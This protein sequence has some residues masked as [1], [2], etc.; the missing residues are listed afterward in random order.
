MV[1]AIGSLITRSEKDAYPVGIVIAY[2]FGFIFTFLYW[3]VVQISPATTPS[4]VIL[5]CVVAG[6]FHGLLVSLLYTMVVAE[7]HPLER[8]RKAGIQV[9]AAY[10]AAHLIFGICVGV[11]FVVFGAKL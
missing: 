1:G 5:I 7:N 2:M 10:S 8:F 3:K 4:E 9:A 11:G 6:F